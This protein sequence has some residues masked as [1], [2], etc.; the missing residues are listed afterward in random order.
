MGAGKGKTRRTQSV[1]GLDGVS[2]KGR[3]FSDGK[4]IFMRGPGF[5]TA[6]LAKTLDGYALLGDNVIMRASLVKNP[7][8]KLT[9]EGRL[10]VS[11]T[12]HLCV[13]DKVVVD[14][15]DPFLGQDSRF[16]VDRKA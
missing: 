3:I 7:D 2:F 4:L 10:K 1:K 11:G 6:S 12:G 8:V 13:D 5:N 16:S 15:L 14:Y 9:L